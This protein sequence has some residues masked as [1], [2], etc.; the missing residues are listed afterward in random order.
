ML[1]LQLLV[2]FGCWCSTLPD[3]SAGGVAVSNAISFHSC[4][5][6]MLSMHEKRNFSCDQAMVERLLLAV[7]AVAFAAC[8][9]TVVVVAVAVGRCSTVEVIVIWFEFYVVVRRTKLVISVSPALSNSIQRNAQQICI[10]Y[11]T[12][13][14]Y[15]CIYFAVF[16]ITLAHCICVYLLRFSH[17]TSLR[18]RLRF[19]FGSVKLYFIFAWVHSCARCAKY[20][21]K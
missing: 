4:F 3:F 5:R 13:I 21:V 11:L 15:F 14:C 9:S 12:D 16:P 8:F 1:L 20:F 17:C 18:L 2:A 10:F 7:V 6:P 19:C